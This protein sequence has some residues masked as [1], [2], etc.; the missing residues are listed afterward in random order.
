[1]A[2]RRRLRSCGRWRECVRCTWAITSWLERCACCLRRV[3]YWRAWCGW[4]T[5]LRV[6][7]TCACFSV[8][9]LLLVF[10]S[11][12]WGESRLVVYALG[13]AGVS[14]GCGTA[15]LLYCKVEPAR[16][17]PDRRLHPA[18]IRK[19]SGGW[20]LRGLVWGCVA[21]GSVGRPRC[22]G[23]LQVLLSCCA[24]AGARMCGSGGLLR[25]CSG[26]P[27][28]APLLGPYAAPLRQF[29]ECGSRVQVRGSGRASCFTRPGTAGAASVRRAPLRV[30][31]QPRRDPSTSVHIDG[32]RP[33]K[34]RES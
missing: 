4:Y 15:T 2:S 19:S 13:R 25:S 22:R 30:K 6:V 1:M 7:L 10:V 33:S 31:L 34:S 21:V 11:P 29:G 12:Y 8:S 24:C 23:W 18:S 27:S 14:S 17:G 26:R 28:A 32:A 9:A 5:V 16:M 3:I 20:C